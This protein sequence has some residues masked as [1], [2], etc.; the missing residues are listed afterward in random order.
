MRHRVRQAAF[1]PYSGNSDASEDMSPVPCRGLAPWYTNLCK[2]RLGWEVLVFLC[3]DR[4]AAEA[5][6]RGRR[7]VLAPGTTT[8]YTAAVVGTRKK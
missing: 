8:V 1:T 2:I 4:M 6:A 3:N 5:E 7:G